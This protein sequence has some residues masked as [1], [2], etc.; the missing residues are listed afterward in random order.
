MPPPDS[1]KAYRVVLRDGLW[2]PRADIATSLAAERDSFV[3][4]KDTLTELAKRFESG[5]RLVSITGI[6]G[7]GKTRLARRFGWTWLGHFPGGVWFCDLASAQTIDGIVHAVAQGLDMPLGRA[8][9][10][11]QLGNA[12]AG[13]GRC[14]VILDNFEQIAQLADSTLGAWVDCAPA[15]CFLVTTR[16]VLGLSG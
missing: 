9:P 7:A 10:I 14:L 4:R 1:A 13:R 11:A 15:A 16:V 6:G 3:G 12:I 5:S 2:L 8:D